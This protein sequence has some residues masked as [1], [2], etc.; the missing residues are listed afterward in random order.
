MRKHKGSPLNYQSEKFQRG[1]K[2][3]EK[4]KIPD[5]ILT[6]ALKTLYIYFLLLIDLV[7][8]TGSGNLDIFKNHE[9]ISPELAL[10]SVCVLLFCIAVMALFYFSPKL[11]NL[12]CAAVTY[13]FVVVLFNQFSQFDQSTFLGHW[14]KDFLGGHVPEVFFV[15]SHIVLALFF[16]AVV[17]WFMNKAS[18]RSFAVYVLL[19][20]FA[21][22]GILHHDYTDSQNQH[23]FIEIFESGH[24]LHDT[25]GK[26][27]FV[28]I[29]LPNLSSYKYFSKFSPEESRN[30][31]NIISGFLAK[32]NFEIFPNAY[33]PSGDTFLN[34]V[35]SV[36]PFDTD[37]T[38][39]HIMD[40]ML[41]YKY[42]TFF[43]LDDD[44]I[45]LRDNQMFDTFK[46][47]GYKISAYKSR[48]VDICRKRYGF[49]VDR[50][51]EKLNRPV[52]L[53]SMNLPLLDRTKLLFIEWM[54]S[55]NMFSDLS[56]VYG[57]LKLFTNP[58]DLP[59]IGI[60]YNNLYVVNSVKT[61]DILADD[62]I[63]DQGRNA[64]FVYADIPSD[65]FIYDQF[66]NI[67]PQ[68]EWISLRNLPWVKIDNSH[69]KRIA[70]AEQSKCL[71]GKLQELINRLEQS[72]V[73]DNTVLVINGMSGT[74]NFQNERIEDLTDDIIDNRLVM[75]AIKS[76]L[77]K[78]FKI[79]N[80]VCPPEKILSHY[81]YSTP[82]C[83][84]LE[85]SDLHVR[86]RNKLYKKLGKLDIKAEATEDNIGLFEKW[87]ETW[88]MKNHKLS[89][90]I[91]I[92]NKDQKQ[93][94]IEQIDTDLPELQ[95]E[96]LQ[97]PDKGRHPDA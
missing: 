82:Q 64:Y 18:I 25:A 59:M 27:K 13:W 36:N 83:N 21:L 90:K 60:S 74:N 14:L 71:Y 11:Q 56:A 92:L 30:A 85:E 86:M 35:D 4:F 75:L 45:L 12:I 41:L 52:N 50:C 70:Y 17:F 54:T 80:E 73:L 95:N 26:Q 88:L 51:I 33:N 32:N 94:V 96:T 62:I 93:K 3:P 57:T 48:G 47:A 49:N 84:G 42:W 15:S 6:T 91:D 79:K 58:E 65:M 20:F 97:N 5:K 87:Y 1:Y 66:C 77:N 31:E 29:M 16:A 37:Q 81:L 63:H 78:S 22:V 67:K 7:L 89:E 46:K 19:F 8:F 10:L 61:F 39:D 34:I 40:T 72:G 44:Y 9:F 24:T 43:N 55:M 38:D 53:Y 2:V 23:D 68:S 76:P 28:Y 69:L